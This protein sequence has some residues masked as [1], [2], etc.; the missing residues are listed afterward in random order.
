MDQLKKLPD[1]E[2]EI[3]KAIWSNTP[4]MTTNEIIGS[5]TNDKEW[6]SQTV[7]TL[8]VRLTK[9]GFV[10]SEKHGKER[11][12]YP[13][14]K[15]SDYLE[16]ETGSFMDKFHSNSFVSLVNSLYKGKKLKKDEIDDLLKWMNEKE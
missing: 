6:K 5:L 3:M 15:E 11:I 12:Y 16:F 4:P 14:I 10:R 1:A 9:R 2:F 7:L 13:L 8:L